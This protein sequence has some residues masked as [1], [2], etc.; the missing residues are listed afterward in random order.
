MDWKPDSKG[1]AWEASDGDGGRLVICTWIHGD[2]GRL[3]F[4]AY[5][6]GVDR[7]PLKATEPRAAQEEA[8]SY[9]RARLTKILEVL[10]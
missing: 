1:N 8:E 2:P 5:R 6:L 3:Y 10:Q 9:L 7:H 4:S